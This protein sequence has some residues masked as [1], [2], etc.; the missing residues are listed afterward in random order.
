MLGVLGFGAFVRKRAVG[1]ATKK[2]K[3]RARQPGKKNFNSPLPVN[4]MPIMSR[5][6]KAT[7]MPWI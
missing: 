7:G 6:D 3:R 4:A 1:P 2:K 5:P